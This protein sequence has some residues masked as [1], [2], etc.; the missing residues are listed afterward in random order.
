V[1]LNTQDNASFGGTVRL[2]ILP[3]GHI[4]DAQLRPFGSA[5]A[6]YDAGPSTDRADAELQESL[7]A[8]TG[9]E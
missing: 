5:A 1:L 4:Y 7:Y 6:A 9:Q 8:H 3:T 2:K